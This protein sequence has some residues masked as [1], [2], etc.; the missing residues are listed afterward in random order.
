MKTH[1]KLT[2]TVGVSA[3]N[4]AQN[5]EAFLKSVLAQKEGGFY[6]EKIVLISDGSTDNTVEIAKSIKNHKIIVKHFKERLGKSSRL[7]QLYS[8]LSS[9]ILVQSDAD[10]IFSHPYVIRDIITPIAKNKKVWMSGGNPQ[11]FPSRT[12]TEKAVNSTFEIYA[13]FR[14]SI[15][16]GDNVFSADGRLLA[17]KKELVKKIV[18]PNDM[19]ANDAFTYY[20]CLTFGYKYKYIESAIV[21]YRSPQTLMDHVRQNTRFRAA[22]LRLSRYFG[23]EII[24]RETYVPPKILFFEEAKQFFKHPLI[25]GY[26]FIVNMYCRARAFRIESKLDAKWALAKTSK[27][28]IYENTH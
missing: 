17:Y 10:V 23:K 2:V 1:T 16:G 4:E 7:N 6:I 3:Y 26:I 28:L 5:I 18:I 22:P 21:F 20:C 25:T 27:K 13:K 24:K 9:D 8:S 19:I 11:P 12:F 15:R 14:K